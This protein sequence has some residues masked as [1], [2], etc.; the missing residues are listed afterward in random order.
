MSQ[1]S[2]LATTLRGLPAPDYLVDLVGKEILPDTTT[3]ESSTTP[4][5]RS[6]RFVLSYIL[7]RAERNIYY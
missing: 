1:S 4:A 2:A 5:T 6:N 7:M 3:K